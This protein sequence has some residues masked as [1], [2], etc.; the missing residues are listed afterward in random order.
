MKNIF[1]KSEYECIGCAICAKECPVN[2][3]DVKLDEYGY[4]RA[5]L[6]GECIDCGACQKV[7]PRFRVETPEFNISGASCYYGYSKDAEVLKNSTS[8]GI[9]YEISKFFLQQGYKI[10][11]VTYDC[12]KD[13]AKHIVIDH[14]EQIR[15]ITGSKYIQSYTLEALNQLGTKQ[16]YV[17]IGTPCQIYS[18]RQYIRKHNMEENFLLIDFFCGG[19]PGYLLWERYLETIRQEMDIEKFKS[20]EFR[21][22]KMGWHTFLMRLSNGEDEYFGKD[23][24]DPFMDLFLS[25]TTLMNDCYTCGFRFNKVYADIRVADFWG[26]KFADNNTGVSM[27]LAVTERGR[28]VCAQ[29]KDQVVMENVPYEL[30]Y[31][32]KDGKHKGIMKKPKYRERVLQ[33]LGD[34]KPLSEITLFVDKKMKIRDFIVKM[35][36]RVLGG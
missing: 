3:L 25:G 27:I 19:I 28:Q 30:I 31:K 7:C 16:K 4:L 33:W 9:A 2:C 1:E 6:I 13:V 22:K 34:G 32:L 26:N 10:V 21:S 8:G 35:Y 11:G 36:N 29:L 14:E 17:F 18:M 12:E 20:V 24:A 15:Q 23:K 5:E